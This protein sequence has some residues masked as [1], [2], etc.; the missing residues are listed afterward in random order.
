M[1]NLIWEKE[2]GR[3]KTT[4]NKRQTA[5]KNENLLHSLQEKINHEQENDNF[6]AN[7]DDFTIVEVEVIEETIFDDYTTID[8]DG[9]AIINQFIGDSEWANPIYQNT[10]DELICKPGGQKLNTRKLKVK[11]FLGLEN[12]NENMVASHYLGKM[13][14]T[15]PKCKALHFKCEKNKNKIFTKCCSSGSTKLDF[16]FTVPPLIENLL[17]N[18]HEK[19]KQFKENIRKYN[20][21]LSFA[22]FGAQQVHLDSRGPYCFKI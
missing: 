16:D 5:K 10:V 3:T 2:D 20:N 19:S 21:A 22:S 6:L 12:Y 9:N 17:T 18:K 15:C 7:D 11:I 8:N 14:E 4:E 1:E 13:D